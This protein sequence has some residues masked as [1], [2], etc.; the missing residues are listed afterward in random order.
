MIILECSTCGENFTEPNLKFFDGQYFCEECYEDLIAE[1]EE[2]N[3]K[4]YKDNMYKCENCGEWYCE[5]CITH[6]DD[7][8]VCELCKE[9]MTG[10]SMEDDAR[11]WYKLTR[12]V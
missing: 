9:S 8:R 12:G 1:C 3:E 2:C 7:M 5:N 10:N 6:S 4:E 11:L